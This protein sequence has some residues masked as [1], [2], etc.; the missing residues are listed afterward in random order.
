MFVF[1]RK[2]TQPDPATKDS[3]EDIRQ[4]KSVKRIC[5]LRRSMQAK[6][7]KHEQH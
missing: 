7:I 5:V 3:K 6:D 4:N 1:E 2:K